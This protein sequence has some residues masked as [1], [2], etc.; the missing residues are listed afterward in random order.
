MLN[1]GINNGAILIVDRSLEPKHGDIVIASIDGAYACKRLQLTPKVSLLSENIKYPPIFLKNGEELDI[2]GVVT[3]A[4]NQFKMFA[5]VDCNSFYA[6]C[7]RVFRP[8]LRTKPVVVLSNNDGCVVALTKEA[9]N[10]GIK[11]CDPW[12]K[13]KRHSSKKVELH[14]HPIMSCMAIFHLES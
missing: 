8:D 5:L 7:E 11:M 13:M 4:I 12:F 2:M 9:K 1:A 6:S 10:L 3:A 14:S